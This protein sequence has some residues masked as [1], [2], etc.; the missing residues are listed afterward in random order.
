MKKF[1]KT[2]KIEVSVD[3]VANKLLAQF[4]DNY[5]HAELMT[6]TIIGT[7]MD[8]GKLPQIASALLGVS[9]NINFDVGQIISC[10]LVIQDYKKSLMRGD[11]DLK[12]DSRRI[13]VSEIIEIDEH[14][15]HP[16][17]IEYNVV[18]IDGKEL[19]ERRRIPLNQ[20]LELISDDESTE[21]VEFDWNSLKNDN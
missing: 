20:C 19:T 5:A 9:C 8:S 7:A 16:I 14:R 17:L 15:K 18:D 12:W 4:K 10:S 21:E 3:A 2:I 6:E 1:N 13:G 11:K